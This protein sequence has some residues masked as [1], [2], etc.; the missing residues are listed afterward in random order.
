MQVKCLI[1]YYLWPTNTWWV[2][3]GG[4]GTNTPRSVQGLILALRSR[5]APGNCGTHWDARDQNLVGHMKATSLTTILSLQSQL[6]IV[7][8]PI[9]G[10]LLGEFIQST[11]LMTLNLF[12]Y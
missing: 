10:G 1:I 3:L 5:I 4:L 8:I 11:L 7:F 6:I 2:F 9:V 12:L